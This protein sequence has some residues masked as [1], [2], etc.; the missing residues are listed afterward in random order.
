MWCGFVEE[1]HYYI[2]AQPSMHVLQCV[3]G[4]K[5]SHARLHVHVCTCQLTSSPGSLLPPEMNARK[6][7]GSLV[8]E[9]T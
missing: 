4:S 8:S 3:A 9:F 5:M 6:A 2:A 1:A 7:G